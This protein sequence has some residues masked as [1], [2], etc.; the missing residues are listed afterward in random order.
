MGMV[1]HEAG[2]RVPATH[3]QPTIEGATQNERQNQESSAVL[4]LFSG[5]NPVGQQRCWPSHQR[6]PQKHA[7]GTESTCSAEPSWGW[8]SQRDSEASPTGPM[9]RSRFTTGK[10]RKRRSSTSVTPIRPNTWVAAQRLDLCSAL[11]VTTKQ[12][13]SVFAGKSNQ[14]SVVNRVRSTSMTYLATGTALALH[15]AKHESE[16]ASGSTRKTTSSTSSIA[17]LTAAPTTR[18]R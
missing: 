13:R 8:E 11:I 16:T 5:R 10:R 9:T 4:P 15:I 2:R 1:G 12:G 18:R 3:P 17:Q 14:A 6:H 7:D